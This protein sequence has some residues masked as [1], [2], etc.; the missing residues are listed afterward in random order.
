MAD[1]P[2][3]RPSEPM[4]PGAPSGDEAQVFHDIVRKIGRLPDDIRRV[5][6]HLGEDS[7]GA[8]AVWI[9]LVARDDLQPSKE[10]ISTLQRITNEVRSQVIN[11]GTGRWPY[12]EIATE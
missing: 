2:E 12:I 4:P 9:T 1:A 11:S 8:P 7:E 10:K 3:A 5:E 6:F